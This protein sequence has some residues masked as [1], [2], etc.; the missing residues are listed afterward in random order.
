ME[1]KKEE[2]AVHKEESNTERGVE[3][4]AGGIAHKRAG[5]HIHSEHLTKKK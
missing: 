5:K 3:Y 4:L 2:E 1:I